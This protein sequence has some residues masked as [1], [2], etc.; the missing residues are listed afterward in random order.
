MQTLDRAQSVSRQPIL[1]VPEHNQ[2]DLASRRYDDLASIERSRSYRRRQP[3]KQTRR[4]RSSL[5][6]AKRQPCM[7]AANASNAAAET[8]LSVIIRTHLPEIA[9]RL[10][11]SCALLIY[12]TPNDRSGFMPD[13]LAE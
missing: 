13:R 6:C 11:R 5:A 10:G 9:A 12:M 8:R 7:S 1:R 2:H 3:S 4:L